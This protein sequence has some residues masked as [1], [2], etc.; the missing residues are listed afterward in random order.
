MEPLTTPSAGALIQ[1]GSQKHLPSGESLY[2]KGPDL[3]K[4][5]WV[6][7]GPSLYIVCVG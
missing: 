1:M 4:I 3:Y 7:G 5:I 6:L 2:Y